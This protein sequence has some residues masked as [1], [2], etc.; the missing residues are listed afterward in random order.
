MYC[1]QC[2]EKFINENAA[3]CTK[4]GTM[5]GQGD[6]YCQDCGSEKKNKNAEF[7]LNCGARL[8]GNRDISFSIKDATEKKEN[9][10]KILAGI[11][12]LFLG[13]AGIH[14]FYLGYN[15]LGAI[16]LGIFLVSLFIFRP[17][18]LVC[19]ICGLLDA[20]QIFRGKITT[21]GG[22]ELI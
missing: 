13:E 15:K 4:C 12:A 14:R 10:N 3:V 1:K 20:V 17:A 2:G 19:Y 9:N 16:Q 22:Q 8:K 5:K 18:A 11:L 21:A 6:N 7:C